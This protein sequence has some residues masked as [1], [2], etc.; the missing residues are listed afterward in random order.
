MAHTT[1]HSEQ[2]LEQLLDLIADALIL[3]QY[4]D[5]NDVEA[6][7]KFI[8]N[9]QLEQGYGG[10]VLALF[11]KDIEANKEDLLITTTDQ[12]DEPIAEL[13]SIAD[14]VDFNTLSIS[15]GVGPTISLVGGGDEYNGRTITDLLFDPD[16]TNPLNVSQF[17]PLEQKRTVVDVERAEEFLDTNIFELLPSGDSRQA[18]INRFFQELN[19]LLPPILPQF[20]IDGDGEVDRESGNWIGDEEYQQNN[21]ISYAQDNPGE[22]NIGEENAYVHRLNSSANDTN[23]TRTI[24]NIYNTI[25]P[26]LTDILEGI[27]DGDL[28]GR[29]EYENQSSG[30]L[31]FRDLNQGIIIRN[32]NQDFIEGLDPSNPTWLTTQY[33][34][35][36][37][38]ANVAAY[39]DNNVPIYTEAHD[40]LL[41]NPGT[42]FTITMWVKFLDKVS[43]GTL[44]NYGNPTRANNP[45]GFKLETYVLNK[46]DVCREVG[47]DGITFG[48]YIDAYKYKQSVDEDVGPGYDERIFNESDVARFVR[49]Q[50]REFKKEGSNRYGDDGGLKD[51]HVGL[52]GDLRLDDRDNDDDLWNTGTFIGSGR[53][54]I[55]PG[56]MNIP[57]VD[58]YRLLQSTYIPEDF[59]EWYFICATYN[60]TIKEQESIDLLDPY[61]YTPDFWLNHVNPFDDTFVNNSGYGNKA[62]VEII[63]RSDL[64]R[65]RGFK[66]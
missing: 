64:L 15:I 16:G 66:G 37:E 49:L 62:K 57:S 23:S 29:P 36:V 3:S 8:R 20:D 17:I 18:R 59:N 21:S 55:N 2:T 45:F 43:S 47:G 13:Q 31:K 25:L 60:P 53:K 24:Q 10:G 48:Q 5:I 42:G 27:V 44:F 33:D 1:E 46:N 50:V 39:D 34:D 65:A 54:S 6:S 38:I 40:F 41:A 26:Y 32:T 14:G 12:N 19:A 35:L 30:Y 11:Q 51:S 28:D 61:R 58:E 52:A 56:D 4:V 7:Q 63:S 9:G 22:S